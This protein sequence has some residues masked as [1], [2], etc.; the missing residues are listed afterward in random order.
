[1]QRSPAAGIGQKRSRYAGP[2]AWLLPAG[3][4]PRSPPIRACRAR[5]AERP[6]A[7]LSGAH[8]AYFEQCGQA[9]GSL[10]T[11]LILFCRGREPPVCNALACVA[12]SAVIASVFTAV[13]GKLR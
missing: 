5:G 10:T 3:A 4:G 12:V 13:Y 6:A 1:M 11:H 2:P 8:S 9:S 7:T